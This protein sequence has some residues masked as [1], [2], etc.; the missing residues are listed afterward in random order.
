M[1]LHRII[2]GV[3]AAGFVVALAAVALLRITPAAEAAPPVYT[4]IVKGV[5][6]GGYDPVAFFTDGKPAKGNKDLTTNYDGA[7]W[8][9]ASAAN[10]DAFQADPAKY[11]PQYGGYCAYAVSK[12]STA[13][14]DPQA[15]T[16]HDGKLYL[17]YNKNVRATWAQDIPG[18]VKKGDAN[19]PAV[20]EK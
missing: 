17:N 3:I 16:V 12:G 14:G 8:R 2:L 5:A 1:A 6:V 10:R 15:W 4:G 9:F 19:W 20:L 13:K 18:N 7:T 11:A